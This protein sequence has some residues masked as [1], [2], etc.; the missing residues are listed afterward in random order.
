ML[1]TYQRKIIELMV[2][3]EILLAELYCIFG[4][5]FSEYAYF[6]ERLTEEEKKHAEWIKKLYQAEKK[7]LVSFTERNTKTYTMKAYIGYV[8]DIIVRAKNDEF[9]MKSAVTKALD[10]ETA[11]IEKEFFTHFQ[12]IHPDYKWVMIKLESETKKHIK[13]VRDMI[14]TLV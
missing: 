7:D 6:W 5:R 1:E 13:E 11:L 9:N 8:E 2:K 10:V 4:D 14:A 12:I 3:Q